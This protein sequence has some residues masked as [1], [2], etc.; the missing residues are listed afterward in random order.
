MAAISNYSIHK[1]DLTTA[2]T[3]PQVIPQAG[4]FFAFLQCLDS[5]GQ[6]ALDARIDVAFGRER[7]DFAPAFINFQADGAFEQIA[8]NWSAQSGKIAYL[9]IARNIG[10]GGMKMIGPP[11]RQLVTSSIGTSLS[12]GAVSVT[13]AAT[14]IRPAN[15]LRQSLMLY[16]NAALYVGIGGS[17][18]TVANAGLILSPGQ[19]ITFDKTTAAIYGIGIASS[20][21]RYLEE[22]S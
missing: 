14:L 12:H 3:Q 1:I 10:A 5:T 21:I 4:D 18:V 20:D 7:A 16:N 6:P 2:P 19:S 22:T 8:I 9:F 15:S 11:V 17:T 13:T